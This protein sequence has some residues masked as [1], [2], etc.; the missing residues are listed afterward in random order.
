VAAHNMVRRAER[1][2]AETEGE[3]APG[4]GREDQV[5]GSGTVWQ[6]PTDRRQ[7]SA[8]ATDPSRCS[9]MLISPSTRQ[10]RRGARPQ[11]CLERPRCCAFW[12]A[13]TIPT[14]ARWSQG[15]G[16]RIG[17]YAQEHETL[18]VGRSVLAN[19][20]TAAP[21]LGDTDV[22]KVLG[23]FLFS[24]DDVDKP[25]SVLSGARKPGSPW[26][27]WFARAPMSCC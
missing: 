7:I 13:L 11:R 1:L 4:T 9:P 2:L 25:A 19:M 10:P 23:S 8:R 15:H 17:Y 3:R 27:C 21:D 12:R 14:P 5:S 18:D 6:G 22:R 16:L 24:G 20:R 26:R